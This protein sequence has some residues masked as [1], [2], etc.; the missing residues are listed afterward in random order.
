MSRAEITSE[1]LFQ[2]REG[3]R[4]WQRPSALP[5]G[6]SCPWEVPSLP[7]GAVGGLSQPSS[8]NC[9]QHASSAPWK[10]PQC[11]KSRAFSWVLEA[12]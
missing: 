3:A 5:R 9:A 11:Q 1:F 10:S 6:P 7:A 2:F 4:G 8:A 12:R